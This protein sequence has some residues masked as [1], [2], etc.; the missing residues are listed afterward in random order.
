MNKSVSI[1]IPTRNEEENIAQLLSEIRSV[2][3]IDYE[4]IVVDDSDTPETAK[5]AKENGAMVLLGQRKGLGQAIIDGINESKREIV[6]VMDADLSHNPIY[7]PALLNPI[8]N[9]GYEMTIGSRYV[10]NGSVLG[11][12]KNRIL[13]SKLASNIAYPISF[14]HDN[15]SGFFAFKKSIIQDK[16]IHPS[17]WKIMLEILVKTNPLAIKEIPIGFDDRVSGKS[18][19]NKKEVI[20]YLNH[21]IELSLHRYGRFIKFCIVGGFGAIMYFLIFYLI[22]EN[23]NIWYGASYFIATL[24]AIIQNYTL[25]HFF[26]FRKIKD[27]NK[28]HIKG[29][30][31]YFFGSWGGEAVEYIIM[32]F[33]VEI[34]GFWYIL[35][36]LIGSIFSAIIKYIFFKRN[37]WQ[38]KPNPK[39]PDYEWQAFF[40][41]GIIQKWWKRNI[42]NT[43]WEWIP[44]TSTLLDIG[45]GSSPIIGKYSENSVGIDINEEK[46]KFMKEKMPNTTFIPGSTENINGKFD[47]IL[48]IEVI[49]HLKD[50][51]SMISEI[52]RLLKVNGNAIIATPDYNRKLWKIAELFTAYKEEHITQFTREKLER[53]CKKYR[54]KPIKHKYIATCDLIEEFEKV[55]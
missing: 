20:R 30:A 52:S 29:F 35:A 32:I 51:E 36:D 55:A 16:N 42:A 49:E 43:I 25:N 39:D 11:W 48:C 44:N 50:P 24:Y 19:F 4:A 3:K 9:Q 15:T 31:K 41:G 12:T 18:N 47:H 34:F 26:T 27:R 7:I 8:I 17:S 2:L 5:I 1:V 46:L 45:C 28:N 54:L 38:E 21:L 22:T 53:M 14:I 13:I 40:R 6:L 23:F 33:L 37:V 10:K